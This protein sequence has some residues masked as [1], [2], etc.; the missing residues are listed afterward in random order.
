MFRV[1]WT[2][3]QVFA[4][5]PQEDSD[6]WSL[7]QKTGQISPRLGRF[8]GVTRGPGCQVWGDRGHYWG[9][10]DI[11]LGVQGFRELNE[12]KMELGDLKGRMTKD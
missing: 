8:R 5:L 3:T 12:Q 6:L 10:W 1:N 11:N 2:R 4:L 7:T 9:I